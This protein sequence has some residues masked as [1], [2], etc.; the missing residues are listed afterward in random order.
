MDSFV[1]ILTLLGLE[2]IM[3]KYSKASLEKIAQC[4]PQLQE[5]CHELIKIM[6]VTILCGYRGKD[7]QNLAYSQGKS[8]LQFPQS[9]HNKTPSQAID[10]AP[11]PVDWNNLNRFYHMIGIIR[12]IAHVKGIKIRS[13][14][15]WDIDGEITDNK[16]NDLPHVELA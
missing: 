4:D 11:Y 13:G 5:I 9:K 10:I 15:D 6:D 3:Y 2:K 7:E 16:F 8:K 14:G 12:G 1:Y